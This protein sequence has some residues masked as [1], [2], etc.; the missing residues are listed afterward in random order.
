MREVLMDDTC[1]DFECDPPCGECK[2]E[3]IEVLNGETWFKCLA[4]SEVCEF[5]EKE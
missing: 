4:P 1:I 3:G 5:E 2:F